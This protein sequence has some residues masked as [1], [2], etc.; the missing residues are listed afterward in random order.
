MLKTLS[1]FYQIK[2]SGHSLKKKKLWILGVNDN[3][4]VFNALILE[5]IVLFRFHTMVN[6]GEA[7][8]FFTI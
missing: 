8:I 2:E 4:H 5:F 1:I 7:F 3:R 6:F